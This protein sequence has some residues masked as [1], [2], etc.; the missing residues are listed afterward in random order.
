MLERRRS[1]GLEVM[2]VAISWTY[3]TSLDEGSCRLIKGGGAL[4]K[5]ERRYSVT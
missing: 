5:E 4:Y 3:G 1:D 2:G